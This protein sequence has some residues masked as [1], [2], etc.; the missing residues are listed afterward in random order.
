MTWLG[1]ENQNVI[2]NYFHEIQIY[3]ILS[4]LN[5]KNQTS[6]TSLIKFRPID[7]KIYTEKAANKNTQTDR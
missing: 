3:V 5:F 1:W 6:S 4:D 7:T 2:T